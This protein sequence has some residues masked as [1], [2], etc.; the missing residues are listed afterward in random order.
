M[1]KIKLLIS[2]LISFIVL[3]CTSIDPPE[4]I[5]KFSLGYIV[6]EYDG[7]LLYNNMEAYLR[8]YD[9]LNHNSRYEIRSS[10]GHPTGVYITNTDNTSNRE[11]ITSKLD[12]IIYDKKLK[13]TVYDYNDKINQFYIYSSNEKFISNKTA[14][15]KIKSENTEELVKRFVNKLMY[16]DVKCKFRKII[17][18]RSKY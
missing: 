13:C 6:G 7:L 4:N 9:M 2:L 12:L 17:L 11:A 16:V 14:L 3:S 8:S 5:S 10:V 15:K 1:Y 18:R